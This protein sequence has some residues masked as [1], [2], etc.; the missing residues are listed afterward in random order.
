LKKNFSLF[1]ALRYL[2]PKRT[3]VS[4]ITLISVLGVTLGVGVLVLVIAVMTGFEAKLKETILGFEPHIAL[5]QMGGMPDPS[6]IEEDDPLFP[7]RWD[8]VQAKFRALPGVKAVFP[9]VAGNVLIEVGEKGDKRRIAPQMRAVDTEDPDQVKQLDDLFGEETPPPL[10]Q[11]CVFISTMLADELGIGLG[12][13]VSLVASK[14]LEEVLDAMDEVEADESIAKEERSDRL[15]EKIEEL[16]LP[17]E[18]EVTGVF[19]SPWFASMIVLPL[20]IGQE[21]YS[22]RANVHALSVQL[23]DPYLVDI[24]AKKLVQEMPEYWGMNT[25][26]SRNKGRFDAVRNERAMMSFVLFFIVIVA[27][28]S[29]M[30]TMITVTVQKRKEIGVMKA[31]GATEDQIIWVFLSQ[32][33]IVGLLGTATGVGL[34]AL[35]THYR[36]EIRAKFSEWFSVDIFPADVYSI[37]EIPA[38]IV[39]SDIIMI[40]VGAFILCALAAWIPAKI[41]ARLDAAKALRD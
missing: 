8:Q 29:I 11:D 31:L 21:L 35:V 16:M 39:A 14:N 30:N 28:F 2:R 4:I 1:L 34:G 6:D 33:M 3:S 38:K 13:T 22:L 17:V 7:S 19:E 10:E 37:A 23:E 20:S 15:K 40:S 32:G 25:W 41:A 5:V 27:A 9:Y 26:I 18:V 24:E 36:N 12:D